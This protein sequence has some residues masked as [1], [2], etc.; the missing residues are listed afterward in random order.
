MASTLPGTAYVPFIS[1][2][3]PD[4]LCEQHERSV[5][6]DNCVKFETLSW[7]LP[8]DEFRHHYART[9]VRVHRYVDSTLAVFHG[10]RRLAA[11]SAAGHLAST[12]EVLR[13][14]AA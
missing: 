5:G 12:E 2:S 1:G 9:R 8:A 14:A 10:P 4:V 6:N 13:A 11:Y 3:L 7:Q